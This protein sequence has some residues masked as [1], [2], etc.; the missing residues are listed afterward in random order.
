[1]DQR[2]LPEAERLRVKFI[3]TFK[4][5]WRLLGNADLSFLLCSLKLSC[6]YAVSDER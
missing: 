4:P 3:V 5:L 2:T 1:M 6:Y